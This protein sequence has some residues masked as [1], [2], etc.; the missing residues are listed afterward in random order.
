MNFDPTEEQQMLIDM[1]RRYLSDRYDFAERERGAWSSAGFSREQWREMAGL[2]V[3]GALFPAEAGGFGG[4]PFDVAFVFEQVGR[5]LVVEPFLSTLMAG[6]VLARSDA[7]AERL[8]EVIAGERILAF[9]HEE[10]ANGADFRTEGVSA[11]PVGPGYQLSGVKSAV[12]HAQAADLFVLSAQ[13]EGRS[14]PSIFLVDGGADG[15]EVRGYKLIDGGRGGELLLR[16]TPAELLVEDGAQ[17]LAEIIALGTT[18]LCWEAVGI[19]DTLRDATADYLRTRKQFGVPIGSFQALQH[20]MA[21]LAIE[22]E[23][24]RSAAINAAAAL[25]GPSGTRDRLVAAAKYTVGRVGTLVAEEAIQMHGGI[26]MT[27]EL[28]LSHYAKR[29]LM[30]GHE[31]GDED[32]H[33]E[34]FIL[35]GAEAAAQ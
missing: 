5:A 11:R 13:V 22:I 6:H 7:P 27:W 21:T 17:L 15:L 20:R 26:G 29:L 33:L 10:A 9:A 25:R 16:G 14:Q 31:L 32:Q 28:P 1:L 2:G 4:D 34:R 24:A 35:L 3:V 8:S 30:I 23:Q 12:S 19:M 18:A